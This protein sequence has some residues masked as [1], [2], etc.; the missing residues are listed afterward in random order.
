MPSVSVGRVSL[1][2]PTKAWTYCQSLGVTSGMR[3]T[4]GTEN[5]GVRAPAAGK[6]KHGPTEPAKMRFEERE[7]CIASLYCERSISKVRI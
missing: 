3:T 5:R 6:R 1:E 2:T 7:T 4:M